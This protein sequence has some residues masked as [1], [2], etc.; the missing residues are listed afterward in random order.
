MMGVPIFFAFLSNDFN[1]II[2]LPAVLWLTQKL[3]V[4]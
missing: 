4:A 1:S 2:A 3:G